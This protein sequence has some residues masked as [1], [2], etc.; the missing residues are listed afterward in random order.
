MIANIKN[1]DG[2]AAGVFVAVT[3]NGVSLVADD[4]DGNGDDDDNTGQSIL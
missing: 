3:W 2:V 4:D 1:V